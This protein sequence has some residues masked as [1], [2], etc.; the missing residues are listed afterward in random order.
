[1]N[2]LQEYIEAYFQKSLSPEEK[3]I[4]EDRCVNDERFAKEVS[5]FVA[6]REAVRRML[7]DEKKMEW[8]NLVSRSSTQDMPVPKLITMRRRIIYIAA[9]AVLLIAVA[10]WFPF[11]SQTPQKLVNQY[12]HNNYSVLSQTMG[13]GQDSLQKG[14][15]AYNNKDYTKALELFE[16]YYRKH[17]EKVQT[18][19]YIGLVYLATKDYDKALQQFQELSEAKELAS[20]PGMFF[21]ALTLINRNNEGDRARAKDLLSRVVQANQTGSEEAIK[22]LKRL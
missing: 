11:Q 7:L 13:V 19:F 14:I 17:P 10:L 8:S 20:N 21:M 22:L 9:A 2:D 1:M 18:K 4:F 12:L 16:G 6:S 15:G 5:W 3:K